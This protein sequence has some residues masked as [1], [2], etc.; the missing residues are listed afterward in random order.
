MNEVHFH[1]WLLH[2]R[3]LLVCDKCFIFFNNLWFCLWFLVMAEPGYYIILIKLSFFNPCKCKSCYKNVRFFFF[4]LF[5]NQE[6]ADRYLPKMRSGGQI[7][8]CKNLNLIC[9][10]DLRTLCQALL[11][12]FT[13]TFRRSHADWSFTIECSALL[14]SWHANSEQVWEK[15]LG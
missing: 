6:C 2:K 7:L 11:S 13:H 3:G 9:F 1:F 10:P 15:K 8:F 4:V 12:G 5:S 14:I